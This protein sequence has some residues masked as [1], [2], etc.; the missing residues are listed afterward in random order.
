ML[1]S[2]LFLLSRYWL[3]VVFSQENKKRTSLKDHCSSDCNMKTNKEGTQA[4]AEPTRFTE[5]KNNYHVALLYIL[6]TAQTNN[7][8]HYWSYSGL[9]IW[10]MKCVAILSPRNLTENIEYWLDQ[11]ANH[12]HSEE[13]CTVCD[14]YLPTVDTRQRQTGP[15]LIQSAVMPRPRLLSARRS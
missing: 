5:C 15:K 11:K 10:S 9:I 3:L 14:F 7:Y 8:F 13:R 4:Q 1:L 2:I 6:L 12:L